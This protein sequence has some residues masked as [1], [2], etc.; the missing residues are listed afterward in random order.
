LLVVVLIIGI[1]AAVAIPL[2]L[3]QQDGAKK[4]AVAAQVTQAKTAMAVELAKGGTVAAAIATANTG[5][6]MKGLDSYTPSPDID[7]VVAADASGFK[8]TGYWKTGAVAG[9]I[10]SLATHGYTITDKTAAIPIP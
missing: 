8:I 4:Q 7:V 9:A 1:L 2:F 5:G 3:N 10:A 6:A